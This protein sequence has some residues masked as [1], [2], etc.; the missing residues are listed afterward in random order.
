VL[1]PTHSGVVWGAVNSKDYVFLR[2]L[3]DARPFTLKGGYGL[4]VG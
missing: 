1:H 4:A 2:G 3:I